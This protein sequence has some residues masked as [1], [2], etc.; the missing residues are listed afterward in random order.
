MANNERDGTFAKGTVGNPTET[1]SA[2][3]N[4][5][6]GP[7]G[8]KTLNYGGGH[9]MSES[10]GLVDG[11]SL[12]ETVNP[13]DVE[14]E[15]LYTVDPLTGNAVERKVGRVNNHTVSGKAG[16]SFVLGEM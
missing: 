9:F 8:D 14:P 15:Y 7:L 1:E 16:K 4:K 11:V 13:D 2:A 10:A 6:Q 3:M 5:N 12:R